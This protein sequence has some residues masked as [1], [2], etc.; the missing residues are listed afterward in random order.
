[1]N[2]IELRDELGKVQK[3]V[4]ELPVLALGSLDIALRVDRQW[5]ISTDVSPARGEELGRGIIRYENLWTKVTPNMTG[6]VAGHIKDMRLTLE[7]RLLQASASIQKDILAA[8]HCGI[9]AFWRSDRHWLKPQVHPGLS[10][11]EGMAIFVDAF[12]VHGV[13]K[14]FITRRNL[15]EMQIEF[16]SDFISRFW[17]IF[18]AQD[19]EGMV[20]TG[21]PPP[22]VNI[23]EADE[24]CLFS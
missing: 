10:C 19:D 8:E 12:R 22:H 17:P 15:A 3:A 6:K 18:D 9:I 14:A 16:Q 5:N 1:M 2:A 21:G 23:A 7:G 13:A 20:Y 11:V 24:G 4:C